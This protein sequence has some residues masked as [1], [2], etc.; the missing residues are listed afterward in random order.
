VAP[1]GGAANIFGIVYQIL[2]TAQWAVRLR[3]TASIASLTRVQLVAEPRS[4]GDLQIRFPNRRVVQQ[5]KTRSGDRTWRLREVIDEVLP[6]LYRAVDIA[7][8]PSTRYEFITTGRMGAWRA[9]A[10]FFGSLRARAIPK[11]PL[12]ALDASTLSRF[13]GS[14]MMTRRQL[15]A[16]ICDAVRRHEPAK[17]EPML[18]TRRKV[19]HLL[20]RFSMRSTPSVEATE[21]ALHTMLRP[22]VGNE[23]AVIVARDRI[24][25]T[26][27]RY[28]S[29]GDATFTTTELLEEAGIPTE[30]FLSGEP[31]RE[32][33]R[34]QGAADA[35]TIMRYR[36]DLS[37]RDAPM[38]TDDRK[39][40]LCLRGPS[41]VGK[42]WA[43]A[44]IA[45]SVNTSNGGVAVLV[46]ATDNP[47]NDVLVGAQ[48]IVRNILGEDAD[49]LDAIRTIVG[50]SVP[51]LP[52][53]WLTVCLDGA[54]SLAYV[55]TL[56]T[57]PLR[58]WGIR[59][60][61]T[62]I[63]REA[64]SGALAAVGTTVAV[65][66]G[67]TDSQLTEFL[68]R[69][70]RRR[71]D[72]R[73]DLF[74]VLRQPLLAELYV[75]VSTLK[76]SPENEYALFDALF[77]RLTSPDRDVL[78]R[79]ARVVLEGRPY[80]WTPAVLRKV[81]A[82]DAQLN[83]LAASAWIQRRGERASM[84][85]ERLLNWAI[86]EVL[87]HD[88]VDDL[89]LL[90]SRIA[91][92]ARD[93]GHAG[94][95]LGYVPMDA[96]W[97][98]VHRE[99]LSSASLVDLLEGIEE[100]GVFDLDAL[101]GDLLSTIGAEIGQALLMRARR[102][103][104][105]AESWTMGRVIAD[106]CVR[107]CTAE[108]AATKDLGLRAL[109][110]DAHVTRNVGIRL[111]RELPHAA[112]AGAVWRE[113]RALRS[114]PKLPENEHVDTNAMRNAERL[115]DQDRA[116]RAVVR[117]VRLNVP[118][119]RERLLDDGT[120]I[121][122]LLDLAWLLSNLDGQQGRALWFE[123]KARL[124]AALKSNG[125]RAI[126][127]CVQNARDGLEVPRLVGYARNESAFEAASAFTALCHLA[128]DVALRELRSIDAAYLSLTRFWWIPQLLLVR[129]DALA[130]TIRARLEHDADAMPY[131]AQVFDEQ[132]L[133]LDGMTAQTFFTWLDG[134][135]STFI[136]DPTSATR[137]SMPD[138]LKLLARAAHVPVL[139]V[140]AP[141]DGGAEAERL[142]S[143]PAAIAAT[144]DSVLRFAMR[145]VPVLL[146]RIGGE[147][148]C[149]MLHEVLS[150]TSQPRQEAATWA[151][152]CG[153][154]NVHAALRAIADPPV[155]EQGSRPNRHYALRSLAA[156][157][158]TLIDL[159]LKHGHEDIADDV[160]DLLRAW[161][162]V[163]DAELTEARAAL[164]APDPESRS[165][166]VAVLGLTGRSDLVPDVAAVAA[167]AP[168]GST[169]RR[170]ALQ[171][172]ATLMEPGTQLPTLGDLDDFADNADVLGYVLR[173]SGT[174]EALQTLDRHL[175]RLRFQ[176]TSDHDNVVRSIDATP[177]GRRLAR[178]LWTKI[179]T[180][181]L[182]M[183]RTWWIELL[184]P[185]L[186]ATT[187]HERSAR[188]VA[189]QNDLA[190]NAILCLA[191]FDTDAA[192]EA[193]IANLTS[194]NRE[195]SDIPALLMHLDE[196]RAIKAVIEH[197]VN[198]LIAAVRWSIGRA[199]R[200]ANATAVRS[201]IL[202]GVAAADA[203]IRAS[204]CEL[205]GW[206]DDHVVE[207]WRLAQLATTDEANRVRDR[208]TAALGRR[209]LLSEM[210]ALRSRIASAQGFDAWRL[211]DALIAIGDAAILDSSRDDL[212]IWPLL[213]RHPLALRIA[214][215]EWLTERAKTIAE[216][217]R[218][219]DRDHMNS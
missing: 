81:G 94:G 57:L 143:L 8:H 170:T 136:A 52:E 105:T 120:S 16:D 127:A 95:R 54:P 215:R 155:T 123:A 38:W 17:R 72:V 104:G 65:I 206:L 40:I 23:E 47:T 9:A 154:A 125:V 66:E 209:R 71:A 140:L 31:F 194:D 172:V 129:G 22:L 37:V 28:S 183:W 67:F 214:V 85:H 51:T 133:Y 3:L 117:V 149:P 208:A 122:E 111:A 202:V 185:H 212:S 19:W 55:R 198:E 106:A 199:L 151:I 45:D 159:V 219:A 193:A 192:F 25:A 41:G 145:E 30:S 144:D 21:S 29:R 152:A 58:R 112:F 101:Y 79:L 35:Q 1:I 50:E 167:A 86:A 195:R 175:R 164:D 150:S 56:A 146:R 116:F 90:A 217:S 213:D 157:G 180:W 26:L 53:P 176:R 33:V 98:C 191:H 76:W 163:P 78:L 24:L 89:R 61:T 168:H 124:L 156:L 153:G 178:F 108:P 201:A 204:A 205:A 70:G 114:A 13:F 119:L 75:G 5:F 141:Y 6:D 68:Q 188:E 203:D 187:M 44:G 161:P 2:R 218:G 147:A 77:Q 186:D 169:L 59:V 200:T 128:P 42:S 131:L 165:R 32:A 184:V 121:E 148:F 162:A 196:F 126:I 10:E 179:R 166:A 46:R 118:W 39:R 73:A 48:R 7:R 182:S 60:A 135:I 115:H 43:L 138:V 110:D 87:V 189:N 109:Q 84:W 132:E 91:G 158:D 197:H 14:G 18:V 181:P 216:S 62:I 190:T 88:H 12:L 160:P 36:A 107:I 177:R 20:S 142:R 207:E 82:T 171:S 174:K 92:M 210:V 134:Q 139:D 211:A 173:R 103:E 102:A 69:H 100:E 113:Y 99:R 4:G 64:S 96:V 11:N 63:D 130:A 49:D 137:R 93:A 74:G 27:L 83:R 15:F 34:Q 97:L 80:P